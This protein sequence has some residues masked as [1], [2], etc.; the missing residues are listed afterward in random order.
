MKS[1]MKSNASKH[2]LSSLS[3]TLNHLVDSM[4]SY[5]ACFEP[6]FAIPHTRYFVEVTFKPSI[7]DN[8]G[9]WC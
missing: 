8:V 9:C 4:A 5:V 7:L 3:R 1:R 2:F 6:C